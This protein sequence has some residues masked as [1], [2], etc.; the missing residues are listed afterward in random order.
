MP[1]KASGTVAADKLVGGA[2]DN[3]LT[4]A[5][6]SDTLIGADGSGKGAAYQIAA[7]D[8]KLKLTMNAAEFLVI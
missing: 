8:K 2:G 1:R 7:F 5:D 4:G 6:G 3:R